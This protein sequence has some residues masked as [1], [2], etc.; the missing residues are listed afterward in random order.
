[1]SSGVRMRGSTGVRA[2]LALSLV[3]ACGGGSNDEPDAAPLGGPRTPFP[4]LYCPGSPS[5]TGTGDNVFRVGAARASITPNLADY[6]TEWDDANGNG[7]Y[8]SGESFTDTNGNNKF[9][10][11]WIAGFGNGRPATGVHSDLWVRAMVF[12]YNDIRI[13]LAVVDLVGW[14]INDMNGARELI[15]ESLQLDHVII[16]S[17]HVHEGPDTIGL[18]G[19]MELVPGID[20]DYMDHVKAQIAAAMGDAVASLQPATLTVAQVDTVDE[21]G[22][23]APEWVGDGRDPVIIDPT[24]TILQFLS[25][26]DP[27]RTVA[28]LIHWAAHPEYTGSRNNLITADFPYLLREIVENGV[29][30]NPARGLPALA[31][32][33]GEVVF[34]NGSVGGQ[35]GP[36]GTAPTGLD[37]NPVSSSGLEKSDALGRNLGRLALETI[38]SADK[39]TDYSDLNVVFRT[40]LIDLAVENTFYHVGGLGGV[41]DRPFHGYDETKPIGESNIPYIES[42]VSYLQ[43]GPVGMITAPGE[44]HPEL[45]V[46]GYDGSRSYGADLVA[47]DNPNPPP[48]ANAP[49]PP[50]L[51]DL[52]LDNPGVEIPLLLGLA[53]D[54]AGYIVPSYNY[55]VDPNA[56]FIEEAEGDHYEETN[57]VGPKVEEQAV[58]A[59]RELVTWRPQ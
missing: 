57:S 10:A 14:F 16:A 28:T 33:G 22:A 23:T 24:M 11:V 48:L 40:G 3:V 5:C 42:R 53:E 56:P 35:I 30:E 46:G 27:G 45:F 55:Q 20:P 49:G 34:V 44:L 51:R 15:S 43:V 12:E 38:T 2:F 36:H 1:M 26:E 8:D 50:Y 52:V 41:F 25:T 54:F 18:W 6:E 59:M 29:A 39:T 7:E 31:G 32:L 21:N 58:G 37:G 17:T 4:E 19:I 13:G 9:D 47:P